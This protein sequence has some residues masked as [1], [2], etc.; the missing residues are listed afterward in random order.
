MGVSAT[1][2]DLIGIVTKSR[3]DVEYEYG[4]PYFDDDLKYYE[5]EVA[6]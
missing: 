2:D 3:T 1:Q 4:V 5:N 6:T